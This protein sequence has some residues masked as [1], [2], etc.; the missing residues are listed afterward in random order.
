MGM[1]SGGG[2]G[3]NSEINVTPMVDIMLVL[4]I[5]FMLVTPNLQ[6]G[7]HVDIPRETSN[8]E[9]DKEINSQ[10]SLVISI[11][12]DGEFYLGKVRYNI[13]LKNKN[14]PDRKRLMDDLKKVIDKKEEKD[15]IVYIKSGINVSYGQVVGIIDIIRDP[16]AGG[17]TQIGLVADRKKGVKPAGG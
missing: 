4:L 17:V 14:D 1:A 10:N 7:I 8:P 12:N 5:I 11:P 13:D 15:R 9:D 16:E 6:Q 2:G 3:L